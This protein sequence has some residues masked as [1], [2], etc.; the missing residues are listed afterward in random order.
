MAQK[1]EAHV[2]DVLVENEAKGADMLDIMESLQ[3]YLKV[4]AEFPES[5]KVLSGGDQLTW[6]ALGGLGRTYPATCTMNT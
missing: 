6:E 5:L 3:S 2:L 4:G 1:S